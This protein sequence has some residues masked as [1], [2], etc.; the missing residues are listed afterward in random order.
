MTGTAIRQTVRQLAARCLAAA[1]PTGA[2]LAVAWLAVAAL[3]AGAQTAPPLTGEISAV[4]ADLDGARRALDTV[5]AGHRLLLAQA[6]QLP[7][8][9]AAQMEVRLQELERR[10]QSLTGQVEETQ[11]RTRQIEDRLDRSLADIEFRLTT[12]EGGEPAG[13]DVERPGDQGTPPGGDQP[14]TMGVLGTLT[15]PAPPSGGGSGQ[16]AALPP[17]DV[18]QQ[19]NAAYDMLQRA[20][21]VGAERA[22]RQFIDSHGSHPLASNAYY[23]LG[24]T[25]Y[26]RSRFEDAATAFAQGYQRYPDGAKAGD[27]LLKLG[28]ALARMGQTGDA[29][30][31]LAQLAVEF[32]DGPVA[33][34]RR[35]EQERQR[36]GCR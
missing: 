1:M 12:L 15:T 19:Y 14:S 25:F 6:G 18:T 16:S 31:T 28:M 29:C 9:Y 36:L 23:W 11:Y 21:Y 13:P 3:P 10:L 27:S 8:G 34:Q 2:R 5:G 32:P 30:L 17:G 26:A 20:D 4:R 7:Q 22:F 35:A 24:E 33:I